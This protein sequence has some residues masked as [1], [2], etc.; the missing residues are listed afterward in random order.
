MEAVTKILDRMENSQNEILNRMVNQDNSDN[1]VEL[2]MNL[3]RGIAEIRLLATKPS[4]PIQL[5]LQNAL[6]FD[7][8]QPIIF[9][10]QYTKR[11]S[12]QRRSAVYTAWNVDHQLN[13]A[14]L[15]II[16][17]QGEKSAYIIGL[18]II[19]S[20][21]EQMKHHR[22][23]IIAAN[24]ALLKTIL[25]QL[26]QVDDK[27]PSLHEQ[28]QCRVLKRMKN[29]YLCK[30][31]YNITV[32]TTIPHKIANIYSKIKKEADIKLSIMLS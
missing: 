24:P 25:E 29:D 16:P 9:L 17:P 23:T 1:L 22:A 18:L 26:D 15:N 7:N 4:K 13:S 19:F 28:E 32:S 8:N 5:Y 12:G 2:Q 3:A 27:D 30:C 14:E 21:L 31:S 11:F 10:F 20:Q 6:L